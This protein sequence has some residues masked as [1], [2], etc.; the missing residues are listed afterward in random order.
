MANAEAEGLV[1][2]P[3]RRLR[4]T[5]SALAAGGAAIA[6]GAGLAVAGGG[7]AGGFVTGI[8]TGLTDVAAYGGLAGTVLSAA[9]PVL[10]AGAVATLAI[11][12][13][14]FLKTLHTLQ[15]RPATVRVSVR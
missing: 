1:R 14:I 9:A 15:P 8:A 3:E 12:T 2:A 10:T 7:G 11:L 13:P 4:A 5:L 6:G